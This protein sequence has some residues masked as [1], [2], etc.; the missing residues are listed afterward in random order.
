MM[1][2]IKFSSTQMNEH[3]QAL[4]IRR[5]VFIDEQRVPE[6]IEIDEHESSCTHF[7]IYDED[8]AVG[9][10]RLRVKEPWIKFERIAVLEQTR[11]KG[12]GRELVEKMMAHAKVHF[13]HLMPMMNSQLSA[14][15][16]YRKLGWVSEGEIFF[17][18]GIPHVQM[19]IRTN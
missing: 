17:E 11:G 16:F 7:L 19:V 5:R 2:V 4:K 1:K 3:A 15:G 8:E 18:A 9:T 6:A 14:E 10:A 12:V 13:P